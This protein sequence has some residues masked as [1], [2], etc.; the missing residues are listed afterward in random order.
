MIELFPLPMKYLYIIFAGGSY[1][2]YLPSGA[3]ATWTPEWSF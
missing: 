3:E 2:L 1:K